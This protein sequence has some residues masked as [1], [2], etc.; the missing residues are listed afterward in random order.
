MVND[1]VLNLTSLAK[2]ILEND[3][4]VDSKISLMEEYT[5]R[6]DKW[7]ENSQELFESGQLPTDPAILQELLRVHDV[8]MKKAEELK[9]GVVRDR[10]DLK[11]KSEGIMA[12]LDILPK[13]LS[14]T[15][16]RKG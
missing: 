3:N 5:T 9:L 2:Q 12:Y 15:K 10:M 1:E 16:M 8:L 4:P 6:F 7:F 13:K 14:V 11:K